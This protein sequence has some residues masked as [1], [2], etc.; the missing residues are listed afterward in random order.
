MR[1]I[2]CKEK[3]AEPL[4][5]GKLDGSFGLFFE[6]KPERLVVEFTGIIATWIAE[7]QWHASQ[8]IEQSEKGVILTMEVGITPELEQWIL[9]FGEHARVIEPARL[10]AGIQKRLRGSLDRYAAAAGEASKA[11]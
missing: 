6:A 8:Q 1:T 10:V 7:R 9:S 2:D 3:P 4:K 11:A 5:R